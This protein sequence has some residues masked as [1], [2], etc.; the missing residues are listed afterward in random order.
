MVLIVLVE[1]T[2]VPLE[3]CKFQVLM[4]SLDFK[5]FLQAVLWQIVMKISMNTKLMEILMSNNQELA[6]V[7]VAT[8]QPIQPQISLLLRVKST[9]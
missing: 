8:T 6:Q 2:L 7:M 4:D 9:Q 1:L 5:M 3:E